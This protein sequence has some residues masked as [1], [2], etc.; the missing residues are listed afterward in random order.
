M[1][2]HLRLISMSLFIELAL[3]QLEVGRS[4]HDNF[5]DSSGSYDCSDRAYPDNCLTVSPLCS[6][7][8]V[9]QDGD[10]ISLLVFLY[11]RSTS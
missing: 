7:L 4:M 6:T 1:E 11:Q 3:Q 9:I 2:I 10:K 5:H 8:K